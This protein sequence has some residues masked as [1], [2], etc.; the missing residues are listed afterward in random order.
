[1][2]FIPIELSLIIFVIGTIVGYNFRQWVEE[3]GWDK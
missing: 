1:M 2:T 3:K